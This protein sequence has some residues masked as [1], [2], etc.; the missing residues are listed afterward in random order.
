MRSTDSYLAEAL[1]GDYG[2]R[3]ENRLTQVLAASYN[4]SQG[5]RR[6]LCIFLDIR[7]PRPIEAMTQQH[8]KSADEKARFDV[9]LLDARLSK[10]VIIEN[11]L[12][13]KLTLEQ[14][15]KYS[16]F[17]PHRVA[18]VKRKPSVTKKGWRICCWGDLYAHL[19]GA[20]SKYDENT[21][22][23]FVIQN[24]LAHMEDIGVNAVTRI[25]GDKLNSLG[26]TLHEIR[27]NDKRQG[28]FIVEPG[29]F[30]TAEKCI[31]VLHSIYKMSREDAFFKKSIFRKYSF[32][33]HF[34]YYEASGREPP[35][36]VIGMVVQPQRRGHRVHS[37]HTTI[38]L[39][40]DR[41][42]RLH[43][44]WIGRDPETHCERTEFKCKTKD[45][46]SEAYAERVISL[47]KKWMR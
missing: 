18:L 19:E 24:I 7:G 40:K 3:S 27:T 42:F 10:Q 21:V 44:Y 9:C 47:W 15:H 34:I 13:D 43:V 39:Y 23:R 6:L 33:P 5:F 4:Y 32:K 17:S 25:D 30:E 8:G 11:K 36:Y 37:L 1:K 20:M 22:D 14:L 38:S 28:G 35:R 2:Q 16:T 46:S 12:D 41:A 45:L 31:S 29:I 26:K